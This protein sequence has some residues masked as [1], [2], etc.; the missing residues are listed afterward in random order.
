MTIILFLI[1]LAVLI[2]VHEFGHFY[3]AKKCGVRVD[4]FGLGFPPR[5]WSIKRGETVYSINAIPFGG[6]VK[7]FGESPD[8]QSISGPDVARSFVH[9]SRWKQTIILSAGIIMNVLFAWVLFG[10]A[11]T[12]GMTTGVSENNS[13]YITDSHVIV[14]DALPNSPATLAGIVSGDEIL[15]FP[16]ISSVQEAIKNSNGKKI[17]FEIQHLVDK[18]IVEITPVRGILGDNYAIGISMDLVGKVKLPVYLAFWEGGKLTVYMFKNIVVGI[19]TLIHN[20]IIGQGDLSQISGPIGIARLVGDAGRLGFVYLLSFTAFISLNL[21]VLNLIPFPALDG[22]R[23]LF[24]GIEAVRRKM[25]SPKVANTINAIGF[26][27]LI[28]FMLFV[29]Y[30]DVVKLF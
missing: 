19:Y 21:A 24:V 11:F 8:D 27:I 13:K 10:I 6:F 28:L 9:K 29:T 1:V 2:L 20:A 26:G 16:T 14:V 22:G 18:K 25:I 3:A 4:E 7:I 17:S 23:I 5:I 12:S 30:R 15:S